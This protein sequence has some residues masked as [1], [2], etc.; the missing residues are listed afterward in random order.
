MGAH[1]LAL[2]TAVVP[3]AHAQAVPDPAPPTLRLPEGARPLRYAVTLTVIP[4]EAKAAGEAVIDLE[5]VREH[6]LLWLNGEMLAIRQAVLADRSSAVRVLPRSDPFVGLAFDPPLP[7]GRHRL[8]IT[9]DADQSRN[10]TRGIFTVQ[11][12]GAW[13]TMTHFEPLSARRAFPCFDEPSH[14]VP[15][16]LT[17]RV[18][19]DVVA[20]SNTQGIEAPDDDPALKRVRFAQTRPLPSYLIAFAVG[21]FETVDAGRVGMRPTP[22]RVIVPRGHRASAAFAAD[23]FP[24]LF[25]H[26]ERWFAI[27]HPY[28]KLDHI[29][30]PLSVNFAMENAGLITYGALSLL[31]PPGAASPRFR[32]GTANLGAHEIAHHWFGN[33]VT[34]MWWDDLWLNE[35]FATW[36]AEKIVDRWRPDYERGT[37]RVHQ[38]AEAINEDALVSARRVREPIAVEGDIRAAFD[39]ITYQKGAT[40]IAMF[41]RWI[42]EQPFRSGVRSYLRSHVDGN[43]TARDFL[44]A[45]TV[46]SRKP[47]APA[48]AT[49]LEQN[50][51]P[52]VAVTLDCPQRGR[53]TLTFAQRAHAPLGV[54]RSEQRWQIPVCVRYRSAA[55]TTRRACTLVTDTTATLPL[56]GSC[57]RYV[58]AND[59]GTGYYVA[60]HRGDLL[61]RLAANR[62]SLSSS[63]RTSVLYDLRALVRSGSVDPAVAFGWID[64]TANVADLHVTLAAVELAGFLRDALVEDVDRGHFDR[65]VRRVFGPRARAL[66]F[67]P[68]RGEGDEP[69]LLRRALLRFV[70]PSDPGLTAQAQ[71]LTRA[72]IDDRAAIDPG[73]VD[74]VLAVAAMTGDA[75]LF[76][77]MLEEARRTSDKLDQRNLVTA[78]MSFRDPVLAQRGLALMLDPSLDIRETSAALW[79]MHWTA[80]ANRAAHDFVTAN[81]DAL[82]ARVQRD[83]PGSWPSFASRLCSARDAED[84]E[85]FWRD[86]IGAY[87]TGARSL[88][89][90]R[91]AIHLCATLREAKG[92]TAAAY[93]ARF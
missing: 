78:L 10:S 21:P 59:G 47:V 2:A 27:P 72:W 70:A 7:A 30:I 19:R 82:V 39:S 37:R 11:E 93:L 81:F 83:A 14:K 80:P 32:R 74:A 84:V 43:A 87:A 49:F 45:L 35:A 25:E 36:F 76:D 86:R 24:Q 68:R 17:L 92:A 20:F 75:A 77:A 48:F 34:P 61:D 13:Y 79:R 15:W 53:P 38:R 58:L 33:L 57:P 12:G 52:Q 16:Q 40:V 5:L 65:F 1:L 89:Q 31:A 62:A 91:E 67:S 26:T 55:A 73:L 28:P 8:T 66:G 41:E 3:I 69:Q 71:R 6:A 54:T 50:G 9:Y 46:A 85:T 42:G 56:Q 18:P 63:E 88:A 22:M 44:E 64:G 60:D 4:G 29:A 51:V 90:A 23:A